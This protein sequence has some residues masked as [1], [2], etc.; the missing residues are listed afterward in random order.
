MKNILLRKFHQL[1]KYVGPFLIAMTIF[2]P[3]STNADTELDR[4]KAALDMIADFA[5]RF[6]KDIPLVGHGDRMEL[7]GEAKA[8]LSGIVKKLADL[9]LEGAG[10]YQQ[11]EYQG[12]LQRDL[13]AGLKSSVD[14]RLKIWKD[15]KSTLVTESSPTVVAPDSDVQERY[16]PAE[17]PQTEVSPPRRYDLGYWS[18]YSYVSGPSF[19]CSDASQPVEIL[20]CRDP[21]LRQADGIMG[22]MYQDLRLALSTS[23]AK[24]VRSAQRQWIKERDRTC[25]VTHQDLVSSFRSSGAVSCLLRQIQARSNDLWSTL[26]GVTRQ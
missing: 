10:K 9:G 12:L 21:S 25:P 19:H 26:R 20:T 6:C 1:Y 11:S 16:T 7:S 8:E 23:A 18:K 3:C 5:D 15:L 13:I 17:P 2:S 24:R 22:A 4:Q 14:C